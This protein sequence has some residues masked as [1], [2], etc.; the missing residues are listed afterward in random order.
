MSR[1]LKY[2]SSFL[3]LALML[4]PMGYIALAWSVQNPL[5]ID[6]VRRLQ[7]P[8]EG[9]FQVSVTNSCAFP[10]DVWAV[11]LATRES[12]RG[13]FSFLVHDGEICI[14]PGQIRVFTCPILAYEYTGVRWRRDHPIEMRCLWSPVGYGRYSHLDDWLRNHLPWRPDRFLPHMDFPI[15]P[16]HTRLIDDDG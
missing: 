15:S 2:L 10:V 1:Q 11:Q 6:A 5:R 8:G 9:V 12:D 13:G 7:G 16:Y 4:I 14:P 3:L